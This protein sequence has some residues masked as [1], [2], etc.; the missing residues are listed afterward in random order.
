MTKPQA[1]KKRNTRQMVHTERSI[2][3]RTQE[4]GECMEW[5]GYVQNGTPAVCHEGK[6]VMVRRLLLQFRG[7]DL[8]KGSYAVPKCGNPLCVNPDHIQVRNQSQHAVAMAKNINYSAPERIRKLTDSA[9]ELRGKLDIEKA[10]EIR[11]SDEPGPVLAERYQVNKSM[12][13]RI[14]RGDAWRDIRNP[15]AGLMA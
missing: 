7:I 8:P 12:I 13:N 5:Q 14:K 9:R 6:V 3:S 1:P 15:F 4:V 2:L 10:R 11:M